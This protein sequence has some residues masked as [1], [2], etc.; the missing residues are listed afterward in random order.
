MCVIL[1]WKR[2]I[3]ARSIIRSIIDTISDIISYNFSQPLIIF[4]L[5]DK[6]MERNINNRFYR[7]RLI[8]QNYCKSLDEGY[9]GI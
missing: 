3:N 2:L 8:S 7:V 4:L 6:E 9:F 5:C 1:L